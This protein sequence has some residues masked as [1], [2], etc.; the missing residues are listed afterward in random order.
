MLLSAL[1]MF[2]S[3]AYIFRW[4][5]EALDH[6]E[7]VLQ[8]FDALNDSLLT[9]SMNERYYSASECKHT[10]KNNGTFHKELYHLLSLKCIFSLLKVLL[11]S[12][13]AG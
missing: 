5:A 12:F 9:D 10:V 8:D 13:A 6:E 7:T 11:Q 4:C 2:A 3:F 1:L